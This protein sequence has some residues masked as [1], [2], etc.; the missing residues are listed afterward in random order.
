[1]VM[2]TTHRIGSIYNAMDHPDGK[3]E[4]EMW[5]RENY[6]EIWEDLEKIGRSEPD[7]FGM[8]DFKVSKIARA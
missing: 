5:A 1:M 3:E 4:I 8:Q 2:L 7:V 6:P